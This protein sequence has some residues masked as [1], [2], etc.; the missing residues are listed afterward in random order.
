MV[1]SARVEP[2]CVCLID[3]DWPVNMWT[4][5]IVLNVGWPVNNWNKL[6]KLE[7]VSVPSG[8]IYF[9]ECKFKELINIYRN[10][11]SRMGLFEVGM[12]IDQETYLQVGICE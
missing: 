5:L 4:K 1:E 2:G 12:L 10:Q 8:Y 6:R 7:W 9:Y 3:V 11:N